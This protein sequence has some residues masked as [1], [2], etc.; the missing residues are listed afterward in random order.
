MEAESF[1]KELIK[2]AIERGKNEGLDKDQRYLDKNYAY[3]N[4]F[5]EF[6][7]FKLSYYECFKCK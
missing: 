5:Q 3:H 1:E 4:K 2:K 6:C 7:L